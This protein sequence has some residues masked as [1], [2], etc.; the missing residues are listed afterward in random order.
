MSEPRT[1]TLI[2]DA[3]PSARLDHYLREHVP[4]LSRKLLLTLFRA[5]HIQLNGRLASKSAQV[6]PGD[7][8]DVAGIPADTGPAPDPLLTLSIIYEDAHIV[9]IDKPA[10]VPSH[11]L[12]P[13]ERG[14]VVS[15]LLS[16]YPELR[17]I[18]YRELESGLLH[19]L[20]NDTSGVLLAVKDQATFERLRE[21]HERGQFDKRYVALVSGLLAPQRSHAF[22][23]ADRRRVRVRLQ[24]TAG[25]KPIV[26]EV[27]SCTPYGAYGLVEV[28]VSLA[29]RHQVR[30]QLAALGHPIAG[31]ALYGGDH[32]PDLTRHFLHASELAFPYMGRRLR[33]R[34]SLPPELSA[35][36]ERLSG[37]LP[38]A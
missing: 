27:L 17:G 1:L 7:R 19:R 20:D 26:M 32:I 38:G 30:A 22:L 25:F 33:V 8:I 29:A 16:R 4:E 31:D 15:A 37:Q 14:T 28:Q 34:A 21:P 13:G 6:Q 11:A 10:G 36:L 2:V 3:G 23:R 9:A 18:G 5:G 35:V 24:P 12:R